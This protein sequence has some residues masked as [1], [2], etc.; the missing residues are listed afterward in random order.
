MQIVKK[1]TDDAILMQQAASGD[2][3]A[4]P[5]TG[6]GCAIYEQIKVAESNYER[7]YMDDGKS[8][9]ATARW[10][11][12]VAH[13]LA[14]MEPLRL[15]PLEM[16]RCWDFRKI[17]YVRDHFT[18]QGLTKNHFRISGWLFRK[19][20][21][22]IGVHF[23]WGLSNRSPWHDQ[24]AKLM[25]GSQLDHGLMYTVVPQPPVMSLTSESPTTL[26]LLTPF[27][28][29][30][31]DHVLLVVEHRLSRSSPTDAVSCPR[32]CT[33]FGVFDILGLS[34]WC[35]AKH[36]CILTVKHGV[37]E[38]TFQELDRIEVPT[39]SRVFL[40]VVSRERR[41]CTRSDSPR[42]ISRIARSVADMVA[43]GD[44]RRHGSLQKCQESLASST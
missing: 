31:P 17:D 18:R 28:F 33:A 26:Q 30:L 6:E 21:Q 38:G 8:V 42:R 43:T 2:N 41:Q 27:A 19:F 35:G 20:T 34:R 32:P 37:C 3:T 16:Q 1:K 9:R 22:R 14:W 4:T 40:S 13:H 10:D 11:R 5:A 15:R 39:A 36:R 12:C 25:Q 24:I 7:L 44:T 23:D 29:E